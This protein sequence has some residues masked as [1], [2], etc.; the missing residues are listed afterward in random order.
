MEGSKPW[1]SERAHDQVGAQDGALMTE[2][3][4]AIDPKLQGHG[5][6]GCG[7]SYLDTCS[8]SHY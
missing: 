2:E 3:S 5:E 4:G 1:G 8:H 7:V 6:G